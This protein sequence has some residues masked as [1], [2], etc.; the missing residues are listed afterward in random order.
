MWQAMYSEYLHAVLVVLVVF[1]RQYTPMTCSPSQYCLMLSTGEYGGT[2]NQQA[3]LVMSL[4]IHLHSV[5]CC[6][7][8]ITP[9]ERIYDSSAQW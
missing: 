2:Q 4:L 6:A 5:C 8:H 3:V 1:I 7:M 9:C